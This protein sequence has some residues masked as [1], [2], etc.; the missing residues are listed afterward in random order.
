MPHCSSAANVV[1]L[2][3]SLHGEARAKLLEA[4]ER[5]SSFVDRIQE[6]C[7]ENLACREGCDGCCHQVLNLRA[8]EAAFLLEGVRLLSPDTASRVWSS[9]SEIGSDKHCPLLQ[10]GRCVV[11]AHRP[12]VCRTHGLPMVRKEASRAVLHCCPEN[13]RGV[14]LARLPPAFLLDESRLSLLMDAV[15]ALYAVETGWHGL[16]VATDELLR[17]G[18]QN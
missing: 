18:L 17:A 3:P 7:A 5:V 1:T 16:R 9:L 14:D 10:D 4:L 13:F 12:V 8:V 15:D 11:Y 2:P 6:T